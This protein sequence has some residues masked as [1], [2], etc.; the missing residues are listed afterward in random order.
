[1]GTLKINEHADVPEALDLVLDEVDQ[2]E[3]AIRREGAKAM[4][5]GQYQAAMEAIGYAK[6]LQEF[7]LEL[8]QQKARWARLEQEMADATPEARAIVEKAYPKNRAPARAK[9]NFTV[10]FPDGHVVAERLGTLT[11]ARTIQEIGPERVA[12]LGGTGS[13]SPNGEPL[14]TRKKAALAKYPRQVTRLPGG[15][16]LN[17]QSP[18]ESK[19]RAVREISRRLGLGLKVKIVPG[20]YSTAEKP[21]APKP[22]PAQSTETSRESFPYAVGKVVQAVFPALQRDARMTAGVVEMLADEKSSIRFKTGG[23]RVLKPRTGAEGETKDTHGH[24]RYYAKLPLEYFGKPYW[25]TSQ[26]DPPAIVPVLG[27]FAEIG[28][29]RD[30]VLA[31][32]NKRW[33][34]S[35]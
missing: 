3:K 28:V 9:T 4:E 19:A 5:E 15:W 33:G 23:N 6:K 26:F 27:L 2:V 7:M 18:T 17:T 25:L 21:A 24:H 31:L 10:R 20:T 13:L 16:Y 11:L 29:S 35:R 22:R 1:M 32:C 30:E 12:Q 14:L 34:G 8:E